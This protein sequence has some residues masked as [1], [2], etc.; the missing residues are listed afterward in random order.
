MKK[1]INEVIEW[2]DSKGIYKKLTPSSQL[3]MAIGELCNEFRDAIIKEK[4]HEEIKK[5]LGDVV[6]F[7]INHLYMKGL[8]SDD[9]NCFFENAI[10]VDAQ[11]DDQL[12]SIVSGTL[13]EHTQYA[14]D[15]LNTLAYRLNSTLEECLQLAH[16]KNTK[17]KHTMKNGK[18]VKDEDL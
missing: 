12:L 10:V 14:I 16:D 3:V 7:Y 15:R 13:R 6:V 18:L 11:L 2:A 17:R 5:E 9:M 4:P 1:L 8:D